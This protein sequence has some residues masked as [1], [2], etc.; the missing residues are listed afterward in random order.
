MLPAGDVQGKPLF[1][2]QLIR[3]ASWSAREERVWVQWDAMRNRV[4]LSSSVGPSSLV[5]LERAPGKKTPGFRVV[6][7][8]MRP[9]NR[10]YYLKMGCDYICEDDRC[11]GPVES[12]EVSLV[13]YATRVG[14]NFC[15]E[16]PED[17]DM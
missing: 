5:A 1:A 16:S 6:T 4:I 9:E 2:F 12:S 13:P 17:G 11:Y 15:L 7:L 3:P 10:Q 8:R 14:N